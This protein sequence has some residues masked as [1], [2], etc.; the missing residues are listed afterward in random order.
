MNEIMLV[1][2]AYLIGS[3]PTSVW[4][5]KAVFGI[6]IRHYGSGN[7]GAT[8]TFR[9]LGTKWGAF[10]MTADITKGVIATSLYLL[11]PFY[12]QNELA[13]T[14][15]MIALGMAAV[16]G[17]VFPIW[18]D[19]KGGKGVATLLGMALAI[20]PLVAFICIIVFLITLFTTRFVSLSS[21]LAGVAF[22]VLILFIFKEK[23]T[24]YRI[25]AIVVALMV[26]VTHQKNIGRLLK[27]EEHKAPLFKKNKKSQ[28]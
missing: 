12:L 19:F 10:V 14:N 9:V 16:V 20:Q 23:E 11:M 15:F 1:I 7:P 22:M 17:H 8:N 21:M 27:G 2:A 28:D 26:V 24:S 25:F 5:S 3:I 18:A 4:V 13:R 6:D